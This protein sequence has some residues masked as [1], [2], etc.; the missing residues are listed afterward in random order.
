MN[1]VGFTIAKCM[2]NDFGFTIAKWFGFIVD[3]QMISALPWIAK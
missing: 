1:R 2:P 3:C